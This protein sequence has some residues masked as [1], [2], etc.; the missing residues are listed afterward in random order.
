MLG[1]LASSKSFLDNSFGFSPTRQN[2]A[3]KLVNA[4]LI[5]ATKFETM[6]LQVSSDITVAAADSDFKRR[7]EAAVGNELACDHAGGRASLLEACI[8]IGA[9]L[10]AII[11][12]MAARLGSHHY[13]AHGEV[14]GDDSGDSGGGAGSRRDSADIYRKCTW[15]VLASSVEEELRK[16]ERD[17]CSGGVWNART[18]KPISV[19]ETCVRMYCHARLA[20]SMSGRRHNPVA[21]V[22]HRKLQAAPRDVSI[23]DAHSSNARVRNFEQAFLLRIRTHG[24]AALHYADDHSKWEAD[25]K[26][27][28]TSKATILHM[29]NRQAAPYSDMSNPIPG[30]KATTSSNLYCM[31]PEP[32]QAGTGEVRQKRGESVQKVPVAVQRLLYER[33]STG[34]QQM[35]DHRLQWLPTR[36]YGRF[37]NIVA[38]SSSR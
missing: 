36:S 22:G 13:D 5:A 38:C 37:S 34:L 7:K 27:S 8:G 20:K 4:A 26:R 3:H 18:G 32:E 14:R 19:S 9:D 29:S 16:K 24:D 17:S 30:I 21:N 23:I 28:F 1:E 25:K 10:G 2:N 11:E 6:G 31:R 33:P 12:D 15:S 35:N